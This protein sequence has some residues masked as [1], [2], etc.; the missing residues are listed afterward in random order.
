MKKMKLLT[1]LAALFAVTLG[2]SC[3]QKGESSNSDSSAPAAYTSDTSES[4]SSSSATTPTYTLGRVDAKH[5]FSLFA[6][7]R[8]KDS[9]KEHLI[10]NRTCSLK[11]SFTPN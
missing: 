9:S 6:Q 4:S 11:S 10:F 5:E 7:N 3:Q 2:T 1:S 8:D